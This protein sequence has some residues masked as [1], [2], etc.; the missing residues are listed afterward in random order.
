M[1]VIS[2][3][4]SCYLLISSYNG[5]TTVHRQRTGA[6]IKIHVH[7]YIATDGIIDDDCDI[8]TTI[9]VVII[10]II[11][12]QFFGYLH[13]DPNVELHTY[14]H[15]YVHTCVHTYIH[16]YRHTRIHTHIYTHT[17]IHTYRRT[18]RH[19][20]IHTYIHT[21]THTYIHTYTRTYVRT[22]LWSLT[23]KAVLL[24]GLT[25]FLDQPHPIWS[26]VPTYLLKLSDCRRSENCPHRTMQFYI[27]T[28]HS[29]GETC[30]YCPT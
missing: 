7:M 14:I 8:K 29:S 17:H 18:D 19:T 13:A 5:H 12:I 1:T 10:I 4:T 11:I 22:I 26:R 24:T 21:H 2:V 6:Q 23:R 3:Q 9:V 27:G 28:L 30:T 16:T 15:T 25:S 20:Y